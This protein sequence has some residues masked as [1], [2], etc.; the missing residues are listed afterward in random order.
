MTQ[1]FNF[2]RFKLARLVGFSL[3]VLLMTS[4]M[5]TQEP[6]P[7]GRYIPESTLHPLPD[8]LIVVV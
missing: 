2:D 6:Q 4:C 7:D 5:I 8:S 3:L 1:T